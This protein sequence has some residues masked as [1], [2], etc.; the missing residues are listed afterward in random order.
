[1]AGDAIFPS[2]KNAARGIAPNPG[3]VQQIERLRGTVPVV[4]DGTIITLTAQSGNFPAP[5]FWNPLVGVMGNHAAVFGGGDE[6]HHVGGRC[7]KGRR[8]L[9]YSRRRS[10]DPSDAPAVIL[11]RIPHRGARQG[12]A[13]RPPGNTRCRHRENQRE[14]RRAGP[15]AHGTKRCRHPTSEARS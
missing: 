12:S 2:D 5:S 1:M 4:L 6:R 14:Q 8:P 11:P 13:P 3:N 7:R 10:R 9:S 15:A